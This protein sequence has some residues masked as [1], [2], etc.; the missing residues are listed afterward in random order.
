MGFSRAGP[1][2]QSQPASGGRVA[3][4]RLAAGRRPQGSAG[5]I[6]KKRG[7][8]GR[9]PQRRATGRPRDVWPTVARSRQ[10]P[11][12]QTAALVEKRSGCRPNP[13][14]NGLGGPGSRG[15][16]TR[17][18]GQAPRRST[19]SI[20]RPVPKVSDPLDRGKASE[21]ACSATNE[22]TNEAAMRPPAQGQWPRSHPRRRLI[23]CLGCPT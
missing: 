1:V 19:Q 7:A 23:V 9:T 17:L 3:R 6:Q 11:N 5:T 8:E 16:V 22:A 14:A 10:G 18:A 15:N 2:G 4:A 13:L 21:E 20:R 12:R